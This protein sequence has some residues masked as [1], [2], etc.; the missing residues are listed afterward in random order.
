MPASHSSSIQ[1]S[2]RH[3]RLV[4]SQD[5]LHTSINATLSTKTDRPSTPV[6]HIQEDDYGVPAPPP[7]SPVSFRPE[8]W[9][10]PNRR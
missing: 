3:M 4:T 7:P 10:T 6:H 2:P 9:A 8:H 1:A 5:L